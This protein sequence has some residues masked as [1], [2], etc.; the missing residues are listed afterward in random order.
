MRVNRRG[1]STAVFIYARLCAIQYSRAGLAP[2][3]DTCS[4][5]CGGGKPPPYNWQIAVFETTSL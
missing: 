2:T 1:I 3:V 4:L 5:F